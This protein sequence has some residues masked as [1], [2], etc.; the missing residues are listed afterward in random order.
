[1]TMEDLLKEM[2]KRDASDLYVTCGLPPMYRAEGVMSP[3][4]AKNIDSKKILDLAASM[5]N[6]EEEIEFTREREMNLALSYPGLGRFRINL[7]YQQNSVGFVVRQIRLDIRSIEELGLPPVLKDIVMAKMGLVLVVGPTGSGKSTTLASM[8][9]YRN[10]NTPGHIITIEEPIEFFFKHKQSIITQR[11]I[12]VD[13]LSY[14]DALK[15]VFRQAPDVILIGEI[16][17]TDT[18]NAALTF[19]ETGRLCLCALY[20]NNASQVIERIINF[21]PHERHNQII[22]LLSLYLKVIISQRLIPSLNGKR[23]ASTEVLLDTPRVKDLILEREFHLLE[24]AMAMGNQEGMLTFGQSTFN[25]YKDGKISCENALAY[26]DN[27]DALRLKMKTEGLEV[28]R[29]RR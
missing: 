21:F 14:A 10:I 17:D 19:A 26:S 8:I 11:E 28:E 25:L 18:M 6:E 2:K 15:N 23:A 3:W 22:L 24:D 27:P 16:R 5:M 20:A 7:F 1:M 13:T 29:G 4:G 12:G 9:E